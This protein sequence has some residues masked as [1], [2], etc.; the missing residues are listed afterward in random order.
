VNSLTVYWF[1]IDPP[2][3]GICGLDK[4]AN[5]HLN[6]SI[7]SEACHLVAFKNRALSFLKVGEE[8]EALVSSGSSLS[9]G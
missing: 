1:S 4:D 8:L 9:N 5:L 2:A 3:W 6:P 7:V